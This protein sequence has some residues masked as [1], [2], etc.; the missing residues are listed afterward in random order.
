[1]PLFSQTEKIT[2][3]IIYGCYFRFYNNSEEFENTQFFEDL[4][5]AFIDKKLDEHETLEIA[6]K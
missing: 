1:M 2:P 5:S 6:E 4:V 3:E